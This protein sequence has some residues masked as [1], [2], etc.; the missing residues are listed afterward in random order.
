MSCRPPTLFLENGVKA[1]ATARTAA[2]GGVDIT[3]SALTIIPTTLDTR[4]V[5]SVMNS[6]AR[7]VRASL[8]SLIRIIQHLVHLRW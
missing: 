7:T 3:R 5:S 2:G 1:L 4:S 8:R 6:L